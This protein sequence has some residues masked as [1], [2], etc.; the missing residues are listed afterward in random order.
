M[1]FDPHLRFVALFL[2]STAGFL[3][4]SACSTGDVSR[5]SE[6]AAQSDQ[7]PS[8]PKQPDRVGADEFATVIADPSVSLI[9]V[10]TPAEF[11]EGH[12][13]GAVN[14]SVESPDFINA[15]SDLDPYTT[16]AVYCRSGNR[17]Q[18]AVAQMSEAGIS[19]IIELETG[20]QGWV[21][22]G[23]ELTP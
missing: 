22:G 13:A 3:P 9:D 21:A 11:N 16:Y 14:I 23:Y 18:T 6:S 12:I 17:S 20:T 10:R 1:R 19:H 2:A 4:L 5:Q 7:A 15:I 8:S